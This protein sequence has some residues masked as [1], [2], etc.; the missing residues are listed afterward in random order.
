MHFSQAEI[1]PGERC[2]PE[3]LPDETRDQDLE[4]EPG[5]VEQKDDIADVLTAK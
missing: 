1:K 4:Q 3:R 5:Q 2:A